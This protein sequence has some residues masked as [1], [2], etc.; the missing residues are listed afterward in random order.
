MWGM[1]N[2]RLG[3]HLEKLSHELLIYGI[4]LSLLTVLWWNY[5]DSQDLSAF[6]MMWMNLRDLGEFVGFDSSDFKWINGNWWAN[7]PDS[8]SM[9][10]GQ[11]SDS[12]GAR[13]YL[14]STS[15]IIAER[16][17]SWLLNL[18]L[19]SHCKKT[20]KVGCKSGSYK[21]LQE[22]LYDSS[23]RLAAHIYVVS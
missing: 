10:T 14:F 17:P 4:Y 2:L 15:Q 5:M 9:V 7:R 20:L 12:L 22:S 19:V 16:G 13:F 18:T 11:A 23:C 8:D 3:N 6:T 1:A 21:S